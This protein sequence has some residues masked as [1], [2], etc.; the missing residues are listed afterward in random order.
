MHTGRDR[1]KLPDVVADQFVFLNVRSRSPGD[2]GVGDGQIV[3]D[4]GFGFAKDYE[5]NLA[6]DGALWELLRLLSLVVGTSRKRLV[7]D[8]TGRA[9]DARSRH[10]GDQRH[11]QACR[12]R[13]LP[14]H[15]VA[16]NRDALVFADAMLERRRLHED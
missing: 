3:L 13:H 1:E 6:A 4:P 10:G 12:R 5:E 11:P 9:R 16:M 8:V 14:G 7:G 2:A 15:D